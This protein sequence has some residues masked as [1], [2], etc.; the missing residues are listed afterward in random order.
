[1]TYFTDPLSTFILYKRNGRVKIPWDVY[2]GNTLSPR[3]PLSE[4][5]EK[6][7]TWGLR[8]SKTLITTVYKE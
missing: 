8:G 6:V 1:M 7:L 5:Q 4:S 3:T 2:P